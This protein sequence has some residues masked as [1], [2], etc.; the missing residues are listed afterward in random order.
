MTKNTEVEL[1]F[2]MRYMMESSRYEKDVEITMGTLC[3][4]GALWAGIRTWSWTRRSGRMA[5]DF[6]VFFLYF[7][8]KFDLKFILKKKLFKTIIK[9]L[10]FLGGTISNIFLI[11]FLAI[12]LWITVFYKVS[13]EKF[14][15]R[16]P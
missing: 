9:F 6:L 12:S 10:L 1:E 5:V 4:I 7:L 15:G 8:F 3:S 13:C 11:V 14:I 16:S 2:E